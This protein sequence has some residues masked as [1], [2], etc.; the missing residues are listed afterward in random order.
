MLFK[1]QAPEFDHRRLLDAMPAPNDAVRT[2][3]R[4]G[5]LLLWVPLNRPGWMRGPVSW[6]LPFRKEKGFE[7]DALGREVWEACDGKRTLEEIVEAFAERHKV[8]FH[9]A[10]L[11]VIA[12]LDSLVKRN[13]VA[14]AVPK[15]AVIESSKRKTKGRASRKKR[16]ARASGGAA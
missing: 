8:H 11:S 12:Y 2:E 16:D 5:T 3:E 4:S 10:R 7:L 1:K 15:E 13:L 9:E 6:F 14:V